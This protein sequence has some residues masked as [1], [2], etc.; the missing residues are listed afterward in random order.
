MSRPDVE[1]MEKYASVIIPHLN[2]LS[3]ANGRRVL[4]F[5]K[6]RLDRYSIINSES[7]ESIE[8]DIDNP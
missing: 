4:D 7:M 3:P 6:T 2:G 8:E 5:I 1:E